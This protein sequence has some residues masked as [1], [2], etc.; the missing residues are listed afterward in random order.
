MSKVKSYDL[1]YKI[2][3]DWDKR[4]KMSDLDIAMLDKNKIIFRNEMQASKIDGL[5]SILI[6]FYH[7]NSWHH[8][9]F[10][11]WE[12]LYNEQMDA[13]GLSLNFA[14]GQKFKYQCDQ[15]LALR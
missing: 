8:H 6:S 10:S 13:E 14:E 7:G 3:L 11:Q 1:K 9:N 5:K 15:S 12:L 2:R 4:S